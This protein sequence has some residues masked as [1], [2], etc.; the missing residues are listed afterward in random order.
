[1]KNEEWFP[2]QDFVG[3]YEASTLGR[4]RCLPHK[5]GYTPIKGGI[6]NIAPRKEDGYIKLILHKNSQKFHR[7]AHRVICAT[8][9]N[10]HE[11]KPQV[12]HKDGNKSNNHPDNLEWATRKENAQHAKN[13]LG[14]QS[15]GANHYMTKFTEEDV[16]T[17]R[18][19]KKMGVRSRQI[20][21]FFDVHESTIG[22]IVTGVNW[23]HSEAI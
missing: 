13:V 19:L 8:F 14:V 17:I 20:G 4:I 1:M 21:V 18:Y 15:M 22:K 11:N 3:F 9:H 2:I 23:K 16:F 6:L 7:Y 12:N 10:N 5:V